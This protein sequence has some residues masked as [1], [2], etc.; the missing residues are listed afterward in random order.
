SQRNVYNHSFHKTKMP[1][2]RL[3]ERHYTSGWRFCFLAIFSAIP[4]I[5]APRRAASCVRPVDRCRPHTKMPPGPTE[6]H[7]VKGGVFACAAPGRAARRASCRQRQF[8]S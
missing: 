2:G 6:R 1:F 5:A 3:T 7:C 8:A 4:R